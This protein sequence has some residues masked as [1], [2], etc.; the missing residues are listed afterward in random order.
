MP[1]SGEMGAVP[2]AVQ[3]PVLTS[4]SGA[5]PGTSQ[6]LVWNMPCALDCLDLKDGEPSVLGTAKEL[7]V[8]LGPQTHRDLQ[9]A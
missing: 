5:S 2:S 7:P 3:V 6:G 8:S 1:G 4:S 9:A